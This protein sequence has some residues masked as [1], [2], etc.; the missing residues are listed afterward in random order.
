MKAKIFKMG[1]KSSK[2]FDILEAKKA[3]MEGKSVTN[4]LRE[5]KNIDINTHDS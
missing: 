3:F 5:Q 2:Y 4:Y 1:I